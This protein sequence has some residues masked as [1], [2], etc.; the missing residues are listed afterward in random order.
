MG[1]SRRATECPY[2]GDE[3]SRQAELERKEHRI[4][5]FQYHVG[6]DWASDSYQVV[7]V[8]S[9]GD[10]VG[11]K[12]VEPTGEGI[13]QFIDGLLPWAAF[14]RPSIAIA[15]EA[16]HGAMVETLI[17]NHLAVFAINPKQW[18]RFRDRHTVAGAKDDSLDALV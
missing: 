7:V 6:I 8:G 3:A 18:D 15:I 14:D 2:R 1:S 10:M 16:P 13:R 11:Q 4:T 9:T 12:H 5:P 17:E